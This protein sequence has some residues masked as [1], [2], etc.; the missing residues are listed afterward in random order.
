MP[1]AITSLLTILIESN[2]EE[3]HSKDNLSLKIKEEK[4]KKKGV[5]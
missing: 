5:K 1:S 3:L 4:S 2:L